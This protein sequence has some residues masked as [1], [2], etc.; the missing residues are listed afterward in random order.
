MKRKKK[1]KKK[2]LRKQNKYSDWQQ[3]SLH[4]KPV[5]GSNVMLSSIDVNY[6]LKPDHRKKERQ[7]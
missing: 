4:S 6:P 3:Y 2:R 1:K 7:V 5:G